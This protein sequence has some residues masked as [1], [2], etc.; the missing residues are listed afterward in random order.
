MHI[1]S[2][3]DECQVPSNAHKKKDTAISVRLP[4]HVKAAAERAAAADHRSVASLA[5]KAL[6]KELQATGYLSP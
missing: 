5:E 6:I 2:M 3:T 4:K 1:A